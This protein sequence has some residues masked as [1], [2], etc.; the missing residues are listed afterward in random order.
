VDIRTFTKILLMKI[1][2]LL[3]MRYAPNAKTPLLDNIGEDEKV[4]LGS[5]LKESKG[6]FTAGV[7]E[8]L[9]TAYQKEKNAGIQVLPLELAIMEILAKSAEQGSLD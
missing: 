6:I 3:V 7:L 4:F 1:R 5:A 2:A 8:Q 9:L